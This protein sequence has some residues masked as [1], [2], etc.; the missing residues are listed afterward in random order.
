MCRREEHQ[1]YNST[2]GIIVS[3]ENCEVEKKECY[4]NSQKCNNMKYN[5]YNRMLTVAKCL[6]PHK[7]TKPQIFFMEKTQQKLESL[8]EGMRANETQL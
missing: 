5:K 6:Q 4:Y 1:E 3:S 7:M 8:S 2:K